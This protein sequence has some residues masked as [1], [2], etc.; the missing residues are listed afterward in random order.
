VRAAGVNL[1]VGIR[2]GSDALVPVL[3]GRELEWNQVTRAEAGDFCRW[4]L[5]TG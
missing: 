3:L 2:H 4:L 1:A 5:I